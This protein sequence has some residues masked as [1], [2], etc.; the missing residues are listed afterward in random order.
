MLHNSFRQFAN[1][2]YHVL[3]YFVDTQILYSNINNK[4]KVHP[5]G[6]CYDNKAAS[7]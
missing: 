7:S 3:K 2:L 1:N 6:T 4:S 5:L